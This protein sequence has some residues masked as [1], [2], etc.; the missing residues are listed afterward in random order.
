MPAGRV[1]AQ[2]RRPFLQG[3]RL[4]WHHQGRRPVTRRGNLQHPPA[5]RAHHAMP[6]VVLRH[7]KHKPAIRTHKSA[8]TAG[9]LHRL[10]HAA[11]LPRPGHRTQA[12]ECLIPAFRITDSRPVRT[13]LLKSPD[14]PTIPRAASAATLPYCHECPHPLPRY[15]L[16]LLHREKTRRRPHRHRSGAL[17]GRPPHRQP[18]GFRRAREPFNDYAYFLHHMLHGAGI[19]LFRGVMLVML[20]AHIAATVALTLQNRSRPQGLRM[21][22]HH[23]GLALLAHHDPLRP[24]AFWPS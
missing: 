9:A 4:Q 6:V 14:H 3:R 18:G 16:V 21:H 17:P 12:L 22:G 8:P 19:W 2:A 13:L 7:T 10:W 15:L 1:R 11:T 20:A 24:D 5:T 23:P